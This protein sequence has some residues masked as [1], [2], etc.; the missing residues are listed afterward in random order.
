MQHVE[1]IANDVISQ[2]LVQEEEALHVQSAQTPQEALKRL[3]QA[4]ETAL[5]QNRET[6]ILILRLHEPKLM[7]E[8][9]EFFPLG[10]PHFTKKIKEFIIENL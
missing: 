5:P 6:F 2:Q 8:L 10:F 4:L 3:F 1:Q 9:G 7:E